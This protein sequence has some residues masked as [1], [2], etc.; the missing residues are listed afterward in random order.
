M[1][2]ASPELGADERTTIT[3]FERATK[4][5]VFIA[6]TAIQQGHLVP[7]RHGSA[8]GSGSGFIWSK[9]G[10]I[11]TNFHVI[12]GADAIKV[13]LADRSEHQAKLVGADPD[14]DLAV[15]QIQ[16]SDGQLIRWLSAPPMICGSDKKCWRSAIHSGLITP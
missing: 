5:V 6:N 10:H 16:V 9:Q 4:S 11:V 14:H 7:E 1:T 8:A 12:Y 2:P 15:L 13:T 3:V